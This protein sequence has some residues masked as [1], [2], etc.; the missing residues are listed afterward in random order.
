MKYFSTE[1]N[2]RKCLNLNT[3]KTEL[4]IYLNSEIFF[5][6]DKCNKYW[7]EK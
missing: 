6:N 5:I 2:D 4:N 1:Q 7:G 3:L